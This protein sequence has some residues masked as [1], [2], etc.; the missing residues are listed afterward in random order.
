MSYER[1]HAM[2]ST[3]P[4]SRGRI[5]NA[6]T[7]LLRPSPLRLEVDTIEIAEKPAMGPSSSALARSRHWGSPNR[8]DLPASSTTAYKIWNCIFRCFCAYP[9][10]VVD[11]QASVS[12][13]RICF[14]C[15][16]LL[17][18]SELL[19]A[20]SPPPSPQAVAV[21]EHYAS[22]EGRSA[23]VWVCACLSSVRLP[24]RYKSSRIP[25]RTL[26]PPAP[27]SFSSL[28]FAFALDGHHIPR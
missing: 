16:D 28:L 20:P 12:F 6:S 5:C 7:C 2:V 19:A 4:L 26:L 10:L 3:M 24:R 25:S 14:L 11:I 8:K 21:S 1:I 22:I 13:Q 27:F 23:V 9:A 17:L 18:F 15:C